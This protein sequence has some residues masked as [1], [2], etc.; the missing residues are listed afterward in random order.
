[1]DF[2][3][4]VPNIEYLL[5][6]DCNDE[7]KNGRD[8]IKFCK[9]EHEENGFFLKQQWET[10]IVIDY[11]NIRLIKSKNGW[12]YNG[13][14][15]E[16]ITS[17]KEKTMKLTNIVIYQNRALDD[18][19]S[20]K[21]F[22][23]DKILLLTEYNSENKTARTVYYLAQT[24]ECLKQLDEAFI[25]Y[26]ERMHMD[27]F[28]EEKYQAAYHCGMIL[29]S[30]GKSF[31]EYSGFFLFAHS[32]MY[33]VEPLV[34]IA[35][36]YI[37]KDCWKQAYTFLY[38]ASKI[39]FPNCGLFVDSE[40]YHYYRWHLLARTAYY[41]SEYKIGY[42]ACKIAIKQRNNSLDKHN[43]NFYKNALNI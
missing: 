9:S 33:R 26:K 16:Y 21:R 42:D 24:C 5:L 19:K 7:L 13:V 1:L 39:D 3:D 15:H 11:Y 31:Y 2:A 29:R 25:Y 20:A 22:E 10:D 40:M 8:L 32:I 6:L 14:V 38:E 12:H 18:D 35:E 37:D 28:F 43:M 36:Y 17:K 30:E 41:V 23:K 27:G 4:M 34:R